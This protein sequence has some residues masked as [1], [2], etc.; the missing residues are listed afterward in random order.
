MGA[1]GDRMAG[2]NKTSLEDR[3]WASQMQGQASFISSIPDRNMF[4]IEKYI[5]DLVTMKIHV[6]YN[7]A[8][9][10]LRVCSNQSLTHVQ[11]NIHTAPARVQMPIST[12][13]CE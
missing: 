6:P 11:H 2:L 7:P 12:R 5:N 1:R 13:E 8:T 4:R 9:P 10:L 3:R